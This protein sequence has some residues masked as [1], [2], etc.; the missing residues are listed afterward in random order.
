MGK[1]LAGLDK[2]SKESLAVAEYNGA[3]YEPTPK[4]K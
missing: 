3:V 1:N 2:A 4:I